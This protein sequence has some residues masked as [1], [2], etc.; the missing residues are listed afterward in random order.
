MSWHDADAVV[1]VASVLAV[2]IARFQDIEL[3][4]RFARRRLI[5]IR[6]LHV[7]EIGR[8][9][10][11]VRERRLFRARMHSNVTLGRRDGLRRLAGAVVG[12]GGHH[13]RTPGLLRIG[14]VAVDG[15]ELLRG[16]F[17]AALRHQRVGIGEHLFRRIGIE[18]RRS[19][20]L[21]RR[22]ARQCERGKEH[23]SAQS[24]SEVSC[25]DCHASRCFPPWPAL[26]PPRVACGSGHP[27]NDRN[28]HSTSPPYPKDGSEIE[29]PDCPT[30]HNGLYQPN[31]V[32]SGPRAISR[33]IGLMHGQSSKLT[34][35]QQ[36]WPTERSGPECG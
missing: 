8:R 16:V 1:G 36:R 35:R 5:A 10:N 12:V 25:E 23:C 11:V 18:G 32:P 31:V 24:P 14:M 15:F 7:V 13:D 26:F 28:S 4:K 6:R 29:P 20:D 3:L 9:D 2:R 19:V 22:A 33:H 21:V 30:N 34:P 27:V 17:E